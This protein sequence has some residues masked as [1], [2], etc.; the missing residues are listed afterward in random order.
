MFYPGVVKNRFPNGHPDI[1]PANYYTDNRAQHGDQGIEVKASRNLSSW[2][3][4]NAENSFLMMFCF[5]SNT[6]DDFENSISARPFKFQMVVCAK[7]EK[8][9]WSE[10]GRK[11]GGRRTATASV[12]KIGRAKMLKNWIYADPD[13][14]KVQKMINK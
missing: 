11:E 7:L 6:P 13:N 4:H 14:Q 3:G 9:D 10:S 12:N 5:D 1:I 2:Q 8:Q